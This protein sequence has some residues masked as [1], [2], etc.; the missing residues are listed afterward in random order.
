[1]RSRTK[2]LRKGVVRHH[3]GVIGADALGQQHVVEP[4]LLRRCTSGGG[5]RFERPVGEQRQIG[6]DALRTAAKWS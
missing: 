3:V 2:A 4:D 1:M 5:D 6:R